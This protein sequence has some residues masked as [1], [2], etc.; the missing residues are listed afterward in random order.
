M[1]ESQLEIVQKDRE[2]IK[3]ILSGQD[4]RMLVI[5]GPCSAWPSEAVIE[6]AKRLK[7]LSDQ[8][9]DKLKI[10]LRVYIQKPRTTIGW[11]GP[12]TQPDPF[13][14]PDLEAGHAYATELMQ[15]VLEIGLPIADESLYLQNA[16]GF[17]SMISWLAVGARSTE[18]QEHR[19]FA[20]HVDCPVGMKNPTSGSVDIGINSVIAAQ[21]SHT[22]VDT[23]P[24]STKRQVQTTG[25]SYAH[26]VLRGGINGPNYGLHNLLKARHALLENDIK[27]PSLIIDA[28]HDNCRANG[29]KYPELQTDVVREVMNSLSLHPELRDVVKGFM[30]ESFLKNGSQKITNQNAQTID[31][32]G[33]SITD[34]CLGWEQTES[35]LRDLYSQL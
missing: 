12:G 10:V 11:A 4:K 5:V 28:S 30:L 8:L 13:S 17:L 1:G 33:L 35:L 2:E 20:S 32:G 26:L 6:Y 24:A 3:A 22:T 7:T 15:Q 34:P 25:N 14:Q 21:H 23:A 31:R 16:N 19:I 29:R 27:N 18:N 9:S